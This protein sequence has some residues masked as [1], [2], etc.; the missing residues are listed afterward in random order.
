MTKLNAL[1]LMIPA[2][3]LVACQG[4]VDSVERNDIA[5]IYYLVAVDGSAVPGTVSH[6]GVPLEVRAGTFIISADGTCFSRMHFVPPGGEE[7][8]R[9]VRAQYTREGSRLI[10]QWENAGMTEGTV[11]GET[12]VMDNHGMIFQYKRS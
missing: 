5:G 11:E 12:F 1:L 3:F 4:V 6:D 7:M 9:E 2:L 8:I 10:M